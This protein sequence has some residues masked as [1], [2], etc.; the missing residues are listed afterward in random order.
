M[1]YQW[2]IPLLIGVAVLNLGA[3]GMSVYLSQRTAVQQRLKRTELAAKQAAQDSPVVAKLGQIASKVGGDVS[4]GL[5]DKLAQA[6]YSH[7]A[8]ARVFMG[9][10]VFFLII[11]VVASIFIVSSL[12]LA[13]ILKIFIVICAGYIFFLLPTVYMDMKRQKRIAELRVVLPDVVDLLEVSTAAGMGLAMAW[14]SLTVEIRQVSKNMADE[15]ALVTLEM[16][17]GTPQVEAM[18]HMVR[19]TGVEELSSLVALLVQTERFGTSIADAL[20][21][22]AASMREKRSLAAQEKAEKIAVK[23]IFPMV[24][25]IYPATVIVLVGPGFMSL[26]HALTVGH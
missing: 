4:Q 10:K 22:F 3:A 21:T 12:T 23:M 14:N 1:I 9:I 13:P 2:L 20:R 25:F 19:R 24:L 5:S 18:R 17:L 8:S 15:M 6:G 26:Y 11:G 16:Q 7:P